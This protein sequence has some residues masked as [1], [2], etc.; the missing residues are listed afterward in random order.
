MKRTCLLPDC[1]EPQKTRGLCHNHYRQAHKLVAENRT[2]W[3]RLE[4]GGFALPKNH[5]RR[6]EFAEWA[7][8]QINDR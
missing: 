2:T 8:S 1:N 4:A 5:H 7:A 6:N 3:A